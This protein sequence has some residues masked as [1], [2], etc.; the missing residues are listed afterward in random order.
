MLKMK[1]EKKQQAVDVK[2]QKD[3]ENKE[4]QRKTQEQAAE[5]CTKDVDDAIERQ[6]ITKQVEI[7]PKVEEKRIEKEKE[8]SLSAEDKER[9]AEEEEEEREILELERKIEQ[10][11]R[12]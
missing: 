3:L 11:R 9:M 2:L 1:E 8:A 6:A 10:R 7:K 4:I 5:S 12:Q